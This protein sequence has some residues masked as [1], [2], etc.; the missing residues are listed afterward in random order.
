MLLEKNGF[1]VEEI[2]HVS[3]VPRTTISKRVPGI[4]APLALPLWYSAITMLKI[5]DSMGLGSIINVY[6]RKVSA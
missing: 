3:R 5:V 6:A 2:Q 4:A 1:V